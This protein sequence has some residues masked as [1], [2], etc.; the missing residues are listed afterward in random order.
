[1]DIPSIGVKPIDVTH[2]GARLS[3]WNDTPRVIVPLRAKRSPLIK[4]RSFLLISLSVLQRRQSTYQLSLLHRDFLIVS[5]QGNNV[6]KTFEI[7]PVFLNYSYSVIVP[8]VTFFPPPP[9]AHGDTIQHVA[10]IPF[11][12]PLFSYVCLMPLTNLSF[13]VRGYMV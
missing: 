3:H 12:S 5:A 8:R 7:S 10:L 2:D 4:L 1:M 9:E 13:L 11:S 6:R